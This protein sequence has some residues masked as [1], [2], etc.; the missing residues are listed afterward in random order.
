MEVATYSLDE[1]R[2]SKTTQKPTDNPE[3]ILHCLF[4]LA[5]KT[6]NCL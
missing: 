1:T 2:Y 4:S 5:Y 3:G 6:C